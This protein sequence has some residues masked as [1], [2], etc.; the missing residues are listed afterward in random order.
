M[1]HDESVYPDAHTFN[2]SRFLTSDLCHINEE[3]RSPFDLVFGFGRRVRPNRVL[4][5]DHFLSHD[6]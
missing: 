5:F 1:L 2:P 3:V 4:V 6:T